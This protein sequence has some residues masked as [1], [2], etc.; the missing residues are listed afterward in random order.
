MATFQELVEDV[1]AKTQ[2]HNQA[3]AAEVT[4]KTEKVDAIRALKAKVKNYM[5]SQDPVLDAAEAV[6]TI[7]N[8]DY[9]ITATRS[10]GPASAEDEYGSIKLDFERV[11]TIIG[12]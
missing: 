12:S 7:N 9:R 4:A 1:A 10:D 5:D 2:T 6:F 11:A 8:V 3:K